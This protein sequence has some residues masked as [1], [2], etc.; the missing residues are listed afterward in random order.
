[1]NLMQ[2]REKNTHFSPL[3]HTS[4]S[5]KV[6]LDSLNFCNTAGVG[7]VGGASLGGFGV[8]VVLRLLLLC[9]PVVENGCR[10]SRRLHSRSWTW[11]F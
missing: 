3:S 6:F 1:M 10:T 11:S 2:R 8:E 4:I 7:V 5:V 9:L